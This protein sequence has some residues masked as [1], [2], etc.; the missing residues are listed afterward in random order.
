MVLRFQEPCL[1]GGGRR[2]FHVLFVAGWEIPGS[3]Y[4]EEHRVIPKP[5]RKCWDWLEIF[6]GSCVKG[7]IDSSHLVYGLEWGDYRATFIKEGEIPMS[8]CNGRSNIPEKSLRMKR[9]QGQHLRG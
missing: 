9:F 7:V 5:I 6:S 4:K 3:F 2:R 1:G 8:M